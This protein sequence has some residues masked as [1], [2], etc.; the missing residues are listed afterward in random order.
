MISITKGAFL[1]MAVGLIV[2]AAFALA[3]EPAETDAVSGATTASDTALAAFARAIADQ[4]TILLASIFP[5]KIQIAMPGRKTVIGQKN[6]IKY[7]PLLFEKY[8]G[9]TVVYERLV[10]EPVAKYDDLVRDAGT[11][12]I[13]RSTKDRVDTVWSGAFTVYWRLADSTWT[14]ERLLVG[15]KER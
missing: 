2:T 4:D 7:A 12:D 10:I 11:A 5:E 3:E 9:C 1:L 13:I 8:G 14:M 15:R 6:V